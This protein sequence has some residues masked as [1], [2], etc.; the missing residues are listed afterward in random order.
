V[1][2]VDGLNARMHRYVRSLEEEFP[3]GEGRYIEQLREA[4]AASGRSCWIGP[5]HPAYAFC[6]DRLVRF[7]KPKRVLEVGFQSGGSAWGLLN[8]LPPDS[9]FFAVDNEDSEHAV[10]AWEDFRTVIRHPGARYCKADI[11]WLIPLLGR[12]PYD[13]IHLDHYKQDYL[14]TLKALMERGLIGECTVVAMHDTELLAQPFMTEILDQF[15]AWGTVPVEGGAHVCWY[16]VELC[17]S[18]IERSPIERATGR[19]E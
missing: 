4:R 2:P 12:K 11:H 13:L 16:P 18:P 5:E 3:E 10:G 9:T 19:N 1:R 7:I 15:G 6:L 17:W 8:S 14:P